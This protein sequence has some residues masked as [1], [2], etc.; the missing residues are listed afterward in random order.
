MR[1]PFALSLVEQIVAQ[2]TIGVYMLS[3]E[4][5]YV[6][7]VGRSDYDLRERIKSSAR[8]GAGYVYFWFESVNKKWDGYML[9]LHLVNKYRPPDNT[10]RPA[11]PR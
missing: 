5:E 4:G 8:E 11:S 2:G 6:H 1:G 9:E 10:L 3:R 7:Y